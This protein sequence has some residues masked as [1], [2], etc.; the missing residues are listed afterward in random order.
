MNFRQMYGSRMSNEAMNRLRYSNHGLKITRSHHMLPK[1]I[2]V[3]WWANFISINFIVRLAYFSLSPPVSLPIMYSD[4]CDI[5]LCFLFS[6]ICLFVRLCGFSLRNFFLHGSKKNT[7]ILTT[8][9]NSAYK[10][11]ENKTSYYRIHSGNFA[12]NIR[13]TSVGYLS[14]NIILIAIAYR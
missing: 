1:C 13:P 2:S 12:L 6:P 9:I 4:A 7:W 14:F 5:S 11:I 3:F 10:W 8:T